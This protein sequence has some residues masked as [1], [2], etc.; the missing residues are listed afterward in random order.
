LAASFSTHVGGIGGGAGG[1]QGLHLLLQ[2]VSWS[3]S[4]EWQLLM[5]SHVSS[6]S[7][8]AG[9]IGGGAGLSCPL[10]VVARSIGSHCGEQA[11]PWT[12]EACVFD[13]CAE[14]WVS[15]VPRTARVRKL[16]ALRAVCCA[17]EAD[18]VEGV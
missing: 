10:A 14:V 12:T 4:I 18:E 5:Q 16:M 7:V 6:A 2:S 9:G 13:P 17:T 3:L 1:K 11:T 8:H 15:M